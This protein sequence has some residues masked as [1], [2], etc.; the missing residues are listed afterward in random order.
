[1]STFR[2][3]HGFVNANP[4][5]IPGDGDP[6]AQ[7]ILKLARREGVTTDLVGCLVK[8]DYIAL[9][10]Y[11]IRQATLALREESATRLRD[12]LLATAIAGTARETDPRDVMVGLA[13]FY[14]VAQQI[15]LTPARLFAEVASLLPD[16]PM[17][18]LLREFG[19]RRDVTLQAFAWRL[20]QTPDGPAGLRVHAVAR[21]GPHRNEIRPRRGLQPPFADMLAPLDDPDPLLPGGSAGRLTQLGA[22]AEGLVAVSSPSG[23]RR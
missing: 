3:D 10:R 2:G 21:R 4:S 5:K 22:G 13:I 20:V 14:F 1:M 9:G 18:G 15:G 7:A 6:E 23:R 19:I 17:P 11:G 16:G 12:A 8:R